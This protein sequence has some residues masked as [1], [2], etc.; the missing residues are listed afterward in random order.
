MQITKRQEEI[1]AFIA[2]RHFASISEIADH[3]Y[4]SGAT[5]RRDLS[6]LEKMGI[7]KSVYG[8]VVLAK[9]GNHI[10]PIGLRD[11]D[12]AAEKNLVAA[13]AAK[14][15]C[16]GA[17]ILLDASSTARRILKYLDGVRDLRIFTNNLRVFREIGNL[18]ARVWCTGGLYNEQ[19]HAFIGP[20][21]EDFIR[22]ISA[23]FLFFSSEGISEEGDISDVSEE[24]TALRR[25]MLQRAARKYFLCDSSKIG[26]RR[27][28]IVCNRTELDGVIC[29]A[30][31][32][33]ENG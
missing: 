7:V 12:N 30:P 28:F 19:N 20:A 8:G 23:D 11:G 14:L 1:I 24:E 18:D 10:T 3:I 17:T 25:I 15:V 27:N 16:D 21:A 29:N 26:V 32:P 5:V 4:T 22:S 13:Q 31:L 33:W 6:A 9:A 2:P